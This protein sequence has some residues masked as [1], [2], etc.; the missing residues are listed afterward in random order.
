MRNTFVQAGITTCVW[1]IKDFE[2]RI[3]RE[4]GGGERGKEKMGGA[5]TLILYGVSIQQSRNSPQNQQLRSAVPVNDLARPL[6]KSLGHLREK[7]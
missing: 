1:R 6:Q 3:V 4:K 7:I 2:E 5:G